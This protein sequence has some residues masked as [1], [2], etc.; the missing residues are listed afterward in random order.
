MSHASFFMLLGP[1]PLFPLLDCDAYDCKMVVFVSWLRLCDL[2]GSHSGA[3]AALLFLVIPTRQ[4]CWGEVDTDLHDSYVHMNNKEN[5]EQHNYDS[6]LH[7]CCVSEF[8]E[9]KPHF[10]RNIY[11]R[12]E[13]AELLLKEFQAESGPVLSSVL[14]PSPDLCLS[15]LQGLFASTLPYLSRWRIPMGIGFYFMYLGS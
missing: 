1:C 11:F 7:A 3:E 5:K 15:R 6:F 8:Q 4:M 14:D 2:T 9:I 13:E 12:L 10:K